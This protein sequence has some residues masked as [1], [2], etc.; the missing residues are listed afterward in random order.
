MLEEAGEAQLHHLHLGR[1]TQV[2]VQTSPRDQSRSASP[3]NLASQRNPNAKTP[4]RKSRATP[5]TMQP[6]HS[7]ER[8]Q[9]TPF[10]AEQGV[11]MASSPTRVQVRNFASFPACSASFEARKSGRQTSETASRSHGSLQAFLARRGEGAT[12][13]RHTAGSATPSAQSMAQAR[14]ERTDCVSAPLSPCARPARTA[15]AAP[16]PSPCARPARTA[17]AVP[18]PKP[19][20]LGKWDSLFS[21][22]AD[23]SHDLYHAHVYRIYNAAADAETPRK[24]RVK[25]IVMGKD[26]KTRFV[27]WWVDTFKVEGAPPPELAMNGISSDEH[28]VELS[29]A[30]PDSRT[31]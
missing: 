12:R 11:N 2:V 30:Q 26:R 27:N 23:P 13:R 8:R 22:I 3:S 29:R 17:R 18:P 7:L 9:S 1:L 25:R 4:N 20:L 6:R 15:R 5:N 28:V 14:T 19:S 31:P 24:T 16:P 10:E 21:N